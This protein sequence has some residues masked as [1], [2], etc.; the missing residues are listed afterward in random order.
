M[1]SILIIDDTEAKRTLMSSFIK[2]KFVELKNAIFDEASCTNEGL[3]K[4]FKK[5]YDL[6]LLDL[7]I[8]QN[9]RDSN[10]DPQKAANLLSQIH[11]LENVKKPTHVLGI[12]RMNIEE[13]KDEQK[14]IFEDNLWALLHY[15]DMSNVWQERLETKIDYLI[16]SKKQLY[17]NPQYDYDVAIFNALE[18][19]E[20]E[21]V[22]KLFQE[23]W[24][25]IEHPFDKSN[26]YYQTRCTNQEGKTIR[27]VTCTPNIM[28]SSAAAMVTTKMLMHFRPKY[29]F[30]TGISAAADDDCGKVNF[31]DIIVATEATDKGNGKFCKE[32]SDLRFK[33]DPKSFHTKP[34]IVTIFDDLK[35]DK[36]TLRRIKD[37]YPIP[38]FAPASELSIITGQVASVP[39]VVAND[40]IVD[41]M[42]FHQRYLRGIEMEAYGMYLAASYCVEPA[43]KAFASLKSVSDFANQQKGNYYRNYAAYTSA[44]LLKYIIENKLEY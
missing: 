5:Q 31:G 12:T 32:G 3:T 6:V 20:N 41:E 30:M 18:T 38:D 22:K 40:D 19:P 10:P 23:G 25:K 2:N 35:G 11:E 42:L 27:I 15:D 29:L 36:A 17:S 14:H 1:L 44:A 26:N 21:W 9:A 16:R 33:P 7:Y 4:M 28:G 24:T 13:I 39:A 37:D 43:P 34:Y 8:T